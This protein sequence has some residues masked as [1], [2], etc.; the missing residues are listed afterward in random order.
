MADA[1]DFSPLASSFGGQATTMGNKAKE[2][3]N[4]FDAL[5]QQGVTD[6]MGQYNPPY[7]TKI[8]KALQTIGAPSEV[9]AGVV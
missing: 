5:G 3:L 6:I 2:A 7:L 9:I 1:L 4:A 8:K